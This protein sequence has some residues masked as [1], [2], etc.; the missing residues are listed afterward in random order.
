MTE[1]QTAK[2][3]TDPT[4]EPT[5]AQSTGENVSLPPAETTAAA[6]VE[7]TPAAEAAPAIPDAPLGPKPPEPVKAIDAALG[8][9]RRLTEEELKQYQVCEQIIKAAYVSFLEMGLALEAI[10]DN[11]LYREEFDS[12]DVYCQE[13]WGFHRSKA[14]GLI[15]A[16]QVLQHL[17]SLPGVPQ[18][19]NESQLR[20]LF[21]L[22]A[23]QAQLAWQY[24]AANSYGRPITA[25]LVKKALKTL[26]LVPNK[27]NAPGARPFRRNKEEQ[28]RLINEAMGELLHLLRQKTDHDVLIKKVEALDS[29]LHRCFSR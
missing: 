16:A 3:G 19:D 17:V 11:E 6:A 1:N 25:K 5:V 22:P 18:P 12:F 26:Q 9:V 23:P 21:G 28:K 15:W 2:P 14:Y 7:P 29:L 27:R 13:R 24:A 4:T 10:R 20:P 8:T